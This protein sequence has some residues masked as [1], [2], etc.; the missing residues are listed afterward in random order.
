MIALG[1][2]IDFLS[3]AAPHAWVKR[4]LH[5]MLLNDELQPYFLSGKVRSEV[6]VG[7]LLLAL[8]DRRMDSPSPE[9]DAKV[10][11][12]FGAEIAD[13]VIEKDWTDQFVEYDEEIESIEGF[14]FAGLGFVHYGT[15]DW[16]KGDMICDYIPERG[17][18]PEHLFHDLEEMLGSEYQHNTSS[19]VFHSMFLPSEKIEMLLPSHRLPSV[20][21][22]ALQS[23]PERRQIGRP[24]KWD[25]EGAMA[26]IGAKSRREGLLTGEPGKQAR[27]ED[28][29][30]EWFITETGDSPAPSQIRSRASRLVEMAQ[31]DRN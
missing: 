2:A 11:A 18:R 19:A 10:R 15:I 31:K 20:G 13:A 3:Q 25:W 21:T 14:V 5:A 30:A 27:I 6:S 16:D 1:E 26:F 8:P 7:E 28:A 12:Q 4:M 29:I 17:S 24:R 22:I 9:R 23:A